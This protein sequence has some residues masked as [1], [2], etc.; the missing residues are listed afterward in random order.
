MG[1]AVLGE[2]QARQE[3]CS[4]AAYHSGPLWKMVYSIHFKTTWLRGEKAGVC[5]PHACQTLA[6]GCCVGDGGRVGRDA[7]CKEA[8][9]PRLL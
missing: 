9:I 3:G 7:G 6:Q 1:R 5:P 4:Q 8:F 2:G